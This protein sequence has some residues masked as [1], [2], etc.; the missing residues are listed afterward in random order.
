[1]NKQQKSNRKRIDLALRGLS[2]QQI[3]AMAAEQS[4][5]SLAQLEAHYG[6]MPVPTQRAG[7]RN[8]MVK[9][10][11]EYDAVAAEAIEQAIQEGGGAANYAF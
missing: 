11:D 9:V 1:M 2:L 10:C 8:L 5:H 3:Y 4:G 6:R 7:L